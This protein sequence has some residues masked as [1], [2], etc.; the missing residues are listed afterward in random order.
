MVFPGN[1]NGPIF[2]TVRMD[3]QAAILEFCGTFLFLLLGLGS[4]IL[5]TPPVSFSSLTS[6]R[7]C[8][9]RH[10]SSRDVQQSV[11]GSRPKRRRRRRHQHR[12]INRPAIIY[13]SLNGFVAV[14]IRLAVLSVRAG[15]ERTFSNAADV[16][17]HRVTGG[18][19]NPA[20]STALWL[21]GAIGP[22][23]WALCCFAQVRFAASRPMH[24]RTDYSSR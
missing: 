4:S 9:R 17:T 24:G 13:S 15:G 23:R 12:R 21:I 16:G 10:P 8:S 2:S 7:H 3:I 5:V 11:T 18:I 6:S 20:V 22:V 1:P 14:D 19:F